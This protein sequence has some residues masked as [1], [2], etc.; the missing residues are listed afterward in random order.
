VVEEEFDN[1]VRESKWPD[2]I[3]VMGIR[4]IQ[5]AFT[6]FQPTTPASYT[7]GPY[8]LQKEVAGGK[9]DDSEES[10]G[11]P[12]ALYALF[13]DW[14][15]S[16]IKLGA[17][18]AH[19]EEF[20]E[21]LKQLKGGNPTSAEV[22]TWI[23]HK[24]EKLGYKV[25]KIKTEDGELMY[26]EKDSKPLASNGMLRPLMEACHVA[27]GCRSA[28]LLPK[29]FGEKFSLRRY[30]DRLVEKAAKKLKCPIC[31]GSRPLPKKQHVESIFTY[32]PFLRLQIDATQV[33]SSKMARFRGKHNFRYLLTAVDTFTKNAW[34]WPLKTLCIPETLAILK[35]FFEEEFVPDILHSDNG[36]QFKNKLLN[37]LSS[38]LG[39]KLKYGASETPQQ[40]PNTKAPKR[41]QPSRQVFLWQTCS[42]LSYK[43]LCT[44]PTQ[45]H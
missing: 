5:V 43:C 27:T 34:A 32:G 14:E 8:L 35:R 11:F 45:L 19:S 22:I 15:M 31:D 44:L 3:G 21:R 10:R 25:K 29:E 7:Y 18:Y 2:G 6:K 1:G 13:Y 40:A 41:K 36:P 26:L 38:Q 17:S 16:I 39:I 20:K 4:Q 33:A 23:K 12:D 37:A 9:D 28:T 30:S 42:F 24:K